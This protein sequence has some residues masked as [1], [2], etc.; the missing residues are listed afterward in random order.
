VLL[1]PDF[2][3]YAKIFAWIFRISW[4]KMEVLGAKWGRGWCDV[5]PNKL[6]FFQF[7]DFYIGEN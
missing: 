3:Q 6:V 7:G 4:P 1:D 5:D 2:L